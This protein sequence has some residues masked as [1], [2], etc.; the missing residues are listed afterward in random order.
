MF[1]RQ[2]TEC[3]VI[4]EDCLE[5]FAAPEVSCAAC[6]A[7]TERVWLQKA[8]GVIG[9]DIPGGQWVHNGICNP[10]GSPR[11]YYSKSD[12]AREAAKR[13]YM[14]YVVHQPPNDS[15]KSRHTSRWV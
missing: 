3:E 8:A 10:D 6:G 4:R 2:C 12:M 15:D 11:K 9:D 7:R 5:P 1:D 13:G 14:N